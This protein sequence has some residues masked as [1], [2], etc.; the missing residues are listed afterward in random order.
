MRF[1]KIPS[2]CKRTQPASESLMSLDGAVTTPARASGWMWS[3]ESLLLLDRVH[4]GEPSRPRGAVRLEARVEYF[5]QT[6]SSRTRTLYVHVSVSFPARRHHVYMLSF[7]DLLPAPSPAH[8][9]PPP[10]FASPRIVRLC[11]PAQGFFSSP[12]ARDD[13]GSPFESKLIVPH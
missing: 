7:R 11:L 1:L 12:A 3:K 5:I 2:L 6:C 9:W 13:A 10:T 4:I 8:L